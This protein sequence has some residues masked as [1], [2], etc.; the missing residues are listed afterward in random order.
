MD[1]FE[2]VPPPPARPPAPRDEA[3]ERLGAQPWDVLVV[4]GGI[5][6]AGI[7]LDAASR[8]LRVALVERDDL[9]SG[10]SSRSSSLVHG[11]LRY[12][13]QYGFGLVR[14]S[15]AERERLR[16]LA[17]HLV[18]PLRFTI[19]H[20]GRKRT[21]LLGVGLWMYDSI[22]LFRGPSRHRRLE[23]HD[24]V[25]RLPGLT[26]QLDG[27][28]YEYSD[29][30]TDDVRLV[31][32]VVRAAERH[33]ATVLTRAEV[34]EVRRAA[35]RVV[36]AT[37]RDRLSGRSVGVSAR[38]TVSATGV[39]ADDLRAMAEAGTPM[40][41]PS[42]GVHLVFPAELLRV[43]TA[44]VVPS[45]AGDRRSVFLIPWGGQ[46]LVGTT[47]DSYDGPL[48]RPAV[49][50]RDADYLCAAVNRAFG[51][52]LSAA[53]AVGAYAGLRP[54]LHGEQDKE[55]G[56]DRLSR[57]HA[58]LVETPGL[59]TVTGG[60][61]TTYRAMA[62]EAV[63]RLADDLGGAKARRRSGTGRIAL[64]LRGDFGEAVARTELL[65][66]R[67]GVDPALARGLVER[68]GDD[69]PELV[70]LAARHG[71]DGPLAPGAPYLAVEA[72][73]AV[74]RE[75]ALAVADV[76]QRRLKVARRVA[77]GGASAAPRVAALLASAQGWG[78]AQA[79]RSV[80]EHLAG[81][82]DERGP[83]PLAAPAAV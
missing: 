25:E 46:V 28:G 13:E 17:P 10:T 40:L 9:A 31:L 43:R 22:A 52:A 24:V 66:E 47:D 63:D 8:G 65:C 6:G 29:C 78:S 49:D 38:W 16:K 33:G 62:V 18:R 42:K 81:V 82:R 60:K 72:R 26:A 1:E 14:E 69:A 55:V 27:F 58:L 77:D 73:W 44:G 53:D 36:G 76:L 21:S 12:I 75:H 39:W 67:V 35:G 70:E 30:R 57:R 7:A 5:T 68:H 45:V 15:A 34:V 48:D 59:L 50:Q 71:E 2:A 19:P 51:T 41:R 64:G 4:G 3:L 23:P 11:G 56:T 37:V 74:E 80:A 32:A 20:Q 83:V 54:L 79:E 61:L